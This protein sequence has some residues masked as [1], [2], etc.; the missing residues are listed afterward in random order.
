MS[1]QQP[2]LAIWEASAKQPFIPNVGK[3]AQFLVGFVLLA[4]AFVLSSLFGLNLT[5]KNLPTLAIPAS[6]AFGFGAVYII[7]AVGVYV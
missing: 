6:L 4:A 3:D 7:C 1:A 2:L 5:A